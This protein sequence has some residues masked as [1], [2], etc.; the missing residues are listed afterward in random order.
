MVLKQ[1][2]AAR[3]SAPFHVVWAVADRVWFGGKVESLHRV[4]KVAATGVVAVGGGGQTP[5]PRQKAG[6][7]AQEAG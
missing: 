4:D 6:Q 3:Q 7:V 1:R 2:Q 5:E